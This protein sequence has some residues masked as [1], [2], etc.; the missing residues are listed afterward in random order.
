MITYFFVLWMTLAQA[1]PPFAELSGGA[2]VDVAPS[3]V[4]IPQGFDNNDLHVQ[5]VLDGELPSSCYFI[6]KPQAN[7]NTQKKKIYLRQTAHFD[8]GNSWCDNDLPRPYQRVVDLEKIAVAGAYEVL[9][10]NPK[11][12]RY[13]RV[14][15]MPI[16][17]ATSQ[18]IDDYLYLPVMDGAFVKQPGYATDD[19][20]SPVI[21]LQGTFRNSCMRSKETKVLV[22]AGNVIEVLPVAEL[23][24]DNICSQVRIPFEERV[25]LPRV[26]RGRYLVHIRSYNSD[27]V[28]KVME[29]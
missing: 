11:T 20:I 19:K 27:S 12:S 6:E 9:L 17:V 18:N 5:I 8:S 2:T 10:F 28:N 7:V 22:R 25:T 14:G 1:N 3:H 26:P 16:A 23:A 21:N 13:A 15:T 29:L 24:K 4:F